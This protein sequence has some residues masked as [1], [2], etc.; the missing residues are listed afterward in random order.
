MTQEEAGRRRTEESQRTGGQAFSMSLDNPGRNSAGGFGIG[1]DGQDEAALSP[2]MSPEVEKTM[3]RAQKQTD[4]STPAEKGR[5]GSEE[6]KPDRTLRTTEEA[7]S[8][9][10]LPVVQEAGEGGESSDRRGSAAREVQRVGNDGTNQ[11]SISHM[12]S[13][14]GLRRVSPSTV[15][16]GTDMGDDT[17]VSSP[18]IADFEAGI[19]DEDEIPDHVLDREYEKPPRIGSDLIQP[20]SPLGDNMFKS[21]DEHMHSAK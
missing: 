20:Q 11:S 17:S 12:S 6:E 19:H 2:V 7:K 18:Q 9:T 1:H 15:G 21:L 5:S 16:T 4:K 13:I 14:P 8:N 10:L 3:Q